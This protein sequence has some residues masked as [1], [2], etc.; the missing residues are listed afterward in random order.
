MREQVSNG[1]E[2][3]PCLAGLSGDDAEVEIG[4]VGGIGRGL[5]MRVEF[6]AA[7]YADTVV[8]ETLRMFEASGEDPHLGDAREVR[9]VEAA[10]GSGSDD[11]DTFHEAFSF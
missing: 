6:V 5:Q 2:G 4:E 7:G 8:V 10:D 11:E 3:F 1:S 9:G